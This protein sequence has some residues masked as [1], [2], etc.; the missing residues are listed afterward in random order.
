MSNHRSRKP[1]SAKKPPLSFH[2][3]ADPPA[4]LHLKR[5]AVSSTTADSPT[6]DTSVSSTRQGTRYSQPS[7]LSSSKHDAPPLSSMNSK[8]REPEKLDQRGD[9]RD[10]LY[11]VP[12]D[13]RAFTQFKNDFSKGHHTGDSLESKNFSLTGNR[14]NQ[15]RARLDQLESEHEAAMA[16]GPSHLKDYF[17]KASQLRASLQLH[18]NL[19]LY[20][21]LNLQNFFPDW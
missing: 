7:N 15:I 10:E 1:K 2:A 13:Y 17:M 14:V 3:A 6:I 21:S 16:H 11:T 8:P 5:A 9:T 18:T 12:E 4:V 20:I 19:H